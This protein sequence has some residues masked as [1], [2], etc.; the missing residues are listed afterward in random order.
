MQ[1]EE[2]L[3][4][5]KVWYRFVE[6]PETIHT[7]DAAEKAGIELE[8][9]TK[10]L[11]LLDQDKNAILAIIPGDCKLSFSKVKEALKLKK[12]R[13]V[14]F[15]EAEQYSG[16]LPGATPMVHHKVKMKVIIDKKLLEFESIYGG[17]GSRERLLEMKV[18]DVIKLN[19]AVVADISE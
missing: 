15:S 1:L 3:K 8:R 14:P 19:D 16:Y 13:L 5:E 2:Y 4:E 12:V 10:S 18:E 7:A 11:V 9:V 17:G 6:K